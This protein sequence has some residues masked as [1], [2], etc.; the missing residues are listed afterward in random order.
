ME[1]IDN[2]TTA[3]QQVKFNGVSTSLIAICTFIALVILINKF[4][5]AY[6]EA[7][8]DG[9]KPA[10]FRHFFK[11]FYIYIYAVVGI[12][13]APVAFTLIE[14]L[15][16]ALQNELINYYN[17]DLDLSIDEA[18]ATFTRDYLDDVQRQHNWIGQQIQEVIV[19][20]LNIACYTTLLYLTKYIFFAFASG[21][22]YYLILLEI[23]TPLAIILY[24]D[25]KTK[26]YTYNYLKNMFVCYMLLP[27]YLIVAAFAADVTGLI[28][29]MLNENKYS[30]FGL[31]LSFCFKLY[32]FTRAVKYT[33]QLI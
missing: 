29:H 1:L 32:L 23:V 19:L 2:I 20:P 15:L 13:V 22:Y 33:N 21:R 12:I 17:R 10:D 9:T 30:M 26:Q 14:T 24:M 25:D 8:Q 18:I 5:T 31:G 4:I 16:G 6:K 28:M 27:A 3:Y 7:F 11:L